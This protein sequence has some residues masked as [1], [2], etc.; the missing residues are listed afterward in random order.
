MYKSHTVKNATYS[1]ELFLEAGNWWHNSENF[2]QEPWTLGGGLLSDLQ[3][4]IVTTPQLADIF[5]MKFAIPLSLNCYTI[6]P[7]LLENIKKVFNY[8]ILNPF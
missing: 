1:K 6:K 2:D 4:L 5:V 7:L 3:K 8:L